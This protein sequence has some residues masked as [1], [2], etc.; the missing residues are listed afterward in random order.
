MRST[1]F[2]IIL[3]IGL[4]LVS[5]SMIRFIGYA[6]NVD[7]EEL[8]KRDER[9]K[10]KV[11]NI[12]MNEHPDHL[13]WFVQI[14]DLHIS[15]LEDKQRIVDFRNFVTETL[16][17]IKPPVVLAS[18]D[19]TDG[20]GDAF[21]LSHQ[22]DVEWKTYQ[23]I[24]TQA[25]VTGK[26]IWLDIRGNHDT[27]NVP[28]S[29]DVHFKRYS[30]QGAKHKRSYMEIVK[31]SNGD[32]YSFIAVDACLEPGPKM[33]YNFFGMLTQNDTDQL[34]LLV[35]ESKKA[36]VNH[37]IWFGHYPTMN[38]AKMNKDHRSLRRIIRDYD[39]SLAYMCGHFHTISGLIPR[40]YALQD[41]SFLEL[42]VGD[43]KWCR[44]FRV[45]AIDHGLFSFVD[46]YNGVWPIVLITN[47]KHAL[48]YV[49]HRHES[50]IQLDSTHIRIL[51]FSPSGI[52][53]CTVEIGTE[54]NKICQQINDNFFVVPWDAKRYKNGLHDLK[55]TVVDNKD[56]EKQVIQP[57]RLDEKQSLQFDLW[58]RLILRSDATAVFQILFWLSWVICVV[59]LIFLRIWHELVKVGCLRRRHSSCRSSMSLFQQFWILSSV[60]RIFWPLILYCVYLT[61]GPWVVSDLVDGHYGVVMYIG[62]YVEG[63]HLAGGMTCFLGFTQLLFCQFPLN[64]IYSKC[65]AQRYYQV[66]GMPTKNHRRWFCM[67]RIVLLLVFFAIITVE[68]FFTILFGFFYGVVGF[69]LGFFR[70]WTVLLHILLYYLAKT[71]P[72]NSL[73]S[74]IYVWSRADKSTG[75]N[76]STDAN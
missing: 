60:D 52:K 59:P 33:P 43:W 76:Q 65:L 21:Y 27:F 40:M 30:V 36:G 9:F 67:L 18:G 17:A 20:R 55:V 10:V 57:F 56:R 63:T 66:I 70:T 15:H 50:T 5:I 45:A 6:D 51:A 35:D 58:A 29:N 37:T 4:L 11:Q 28:L 48:F 19:L 38:I 53:N 62:N 14:S 34:Q 22:N 47:P 42:E 74:S 1:I 7:E 72:D 44:K 12:H 54:G 25:N 69:F 68:I 13:F 39:N 23:D 61:V 32:L 49:P 41:E 3:C 71:A 73:R 26:T 46:V 24:L 64:W 8:Q 31:G 2:A 75:E 16:D